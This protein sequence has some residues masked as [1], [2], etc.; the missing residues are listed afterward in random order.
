MVNRCGCVAAGSLVVGVVLAIGCAV[1][2]PLLTTFL[3]KVVDQ[4]INV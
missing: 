2:I 4:V 1:G 3:S